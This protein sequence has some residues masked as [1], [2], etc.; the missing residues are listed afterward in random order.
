MSYRR[1]YKIN[2]DLITK[3]QATILEET[4]PP[5]PPPPPPPLVDKTSALLD[6]IRN[7]QLTSDEY[8]HSSFFRIDSKSG[9]LLYRAFMK[10]QK[11]EKA[12]DSHAQTMLHCLSH[13]PGIEAWHSSC[14][15]SCVIAKL[16]Y[17]ATGISPNPIC[18]V[19]T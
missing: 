4:P 12:R 16:Y 2:L 15:L 7:D 10:K 11:F 8:F 19:T 6:I 14:C 1:C 18:V 3:D 9:Q 5:P 17:Y 13:I